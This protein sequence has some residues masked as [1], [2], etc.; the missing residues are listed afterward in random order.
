MKTV[1]LL[2]TLLNLVCFSQAQSQSQRASPLWIHL[3]PKTKGVFSPQPA[4]IV[5]TLNVVVVEGAGSAASSNVARGL[6]RSDGLQMWQTPENALGNVILSPLHST[7]V[8]FFV[9]SP[10]GQG[11]GTQA[12]DAQTGLTLWQTS[13]TDACCTLISVYES[14][15]ALTDTTGRQLQLVNT[16]TGQKL[17][18]KQNDTHSLLAEEIRAQGGPLAAVTVRGLPHLIDLD[19]ATRTPVSL[20]QVVPGWEN[21]ETTRRGTA[22]VIGPVIYAN[23]NLPAVPAA[24]SLIVYVNEENGNPGSSLWP[25]YLVRL[26]GAGERRW[27]FPASISPSDR[28]NWADRIG[29][30]WRIDSANVVIAEN[31]QYTLFSV[32]M[33]DGKPLWTRVWRGVQQQGAGRGL[34]ESAAVYRAGM[35][36]L[37]ISDA[38]L[39]R[40]RNHAAR[41]SPVQRRLDYVEAG[42]GKATF[43]ANLTLG[44]TTGD[45]VGA[46]LS[47][48]GD[49]LF[50]VTLNAVYAYDGRKLL[51]SVLP[52]VSPVTP[53]QKPTA[54]QPLPHYRYTPL[55]GLPSNQRCEQKGTQA[56][57]INNRGQVVGQSW[58]RP[59]MWQNG[60]LR[61]LPL[62]P[63]DNVGAAYAI[64]NSGD[65]LIHSERRV[66][67]QMSLRRDFLLRQGRMVPFATHNSK[68]ITTLAGLNDQGQVVGQQ[69]LASDVPYTDPLRQK[70][71]P[72]SFIWRNNTMTWLNEG[73]IP[74]F[75]LTPSAINNR[76]Q[77]VGM[78]ALYNPRFGGRSAEGPILWENGHTRKLPGLTLNPIA[79]NAAG[80]IVGTVSGT[81]QNSDDSA[82]Q[83]YA[84]AVWQAD[85]Q[86]QLRSGE[87]GDYETAHAVNRQGQVVGDSSVGA[88]V[89]Q[90][91][92]M[93]FL[94]GLLPPAS[95]WPQSAAMGIN[96][97]GQIVGYSQSLVKRKQGNG[98]S[99]YVLGAFLL[100][101]RSQ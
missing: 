97:R 93:L 1:F 84:P 75:V 46:S 31:G 91:G 2:L 99:D 7:S 36:V 28:I 57:A 92:Q 43:I 23:P 53:A 72:R 49:D 74:A 48:S 64:N 100:T 42:T 32:R 38:Q 18:P 73:T 24:A 6:R 8:V 87:G 60:K 21:P 41:P 3:V 59:V 54:A 10:Y 27:Q 95:G 14:V 52:A 94:A 90:A 45:S 19:K 30:T 44:A 51:H 68:L 101:P 12:V 5:V 79:L 66:K 83:Y 40:E 67:S 22:D 13:G 88:F 26:S 33:S 50:A 85:W 81:T 35:F 16:R 71:V 63:G 78:L 29:L 58:E 37:S 25:K 39:K 86:T 61:V 89:W 56:L 11:S 15:T 98:G 34:L 62:L 69:V 96:D 55:A 47:I 9:P 20:K 4:S 76:G 80:L 82:V 65:I 77:I 70:F 17:D